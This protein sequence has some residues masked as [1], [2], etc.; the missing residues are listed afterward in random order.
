MVSW[1]WWRSRTFLL[2]LCGS[3]L[4]PISTLEVLLLPAS[5]WDFLGPLHSC[6]ERQKEMH[7]SGRAS[8]E[9]LKLP[10]SL[11]VGLSVGLGWMLVW[12]RLTFRL[13]PGTNFIPAVARETKFPEGGQV[14]E[15][16]PLGWMSNLVPSASE[17]RIR[18]HVHRESWVGGNRNGT[19]CNLS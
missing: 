11:G 12:S 14:T 7:H 13:L 4:L 6:K 10:D 17:C 1:F 16:A 15:T 3:F 2:A 9:A 19:Q 5:A 8:G 18:G